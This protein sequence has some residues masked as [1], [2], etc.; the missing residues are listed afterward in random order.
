MSKVYLNIGSGQ[1]PFKP[2]FLNYDVQPEYVQPTLAAGCN[3]LEDPFTLEHASVDIVVLHHVLEHFG[4]GEADDLITF[5]H[6]LLKPGGSMIISI[7]NVRSLARMWLMGGSVMDTQLF[8][9]NIYGAY[10]G[11]EADRHKWGYDWNSLMDYTKKWHWENRRPFDWRVI[12]G[13]D[14]ARDDRW[15][16]V[17]ECVK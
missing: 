14:I 12:E 6:R 13:A 17:M 15:I 3:W 2:P 7:P 16:S 10:M 4:C 9:T 11:D 8:M 1:R 5:Y